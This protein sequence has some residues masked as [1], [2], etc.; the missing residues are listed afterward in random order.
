MPR[1][2]PD[3]SGERCRDSE[4]V[5]SNTVR[6]DWPFAAG[7]GVCTVSTHRYTAW[8]RHEPT[9]PQPNIRTIRRH[10]VT[11]QRRPISRWT[12]A[13]VNLSSLPSEAVEDGHAVRPVRISHR[14]ECL[15]FTLLGRDLEKQC[16]WPEPFVSLDDAAGCCG[17]CCPVWLHLPVSLIPADPVMVVIEFGRRSQSSGHGGLCESLKNALRL[18]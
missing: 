12:D 11:G 5:D 2:K 14:R 3:L 1:F 8:P 13:C 18:S 4:A 9:V 6:F 16:D 10:C 7:S 17:A 15:F